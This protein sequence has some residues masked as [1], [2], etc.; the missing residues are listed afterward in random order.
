MTS[1]ILNNEEI[2]A[3]TNNNIV[4]GALKSYDFSSQE[5][6]TRG[7]YPTLDI[8]Y[9]RFIRTFKIAL[10]NFLHT[11]MVVEIENIHACK[12]NEYQQTLSNPIALNFLNIQPLKGVGLITVEFE[13]LY[14][15][16][17]TYFGGALSQNKNTLR[18][19]T[20]FENRMNTLLLNKFIEHLTQAWSPV[21]ALDFKI[22]NFETNP[23]LTTQYSPNE[24]MLLTCF[25]L[26]WAA[27]EGKVH[28]VLPYNIFEPIKS[29]IGTGFK[30]DRED[31]N[32]NWQKSITKELL[33]V[34]VDIGVIPATAS[35]NVKK[36]S[37]IKVGDIIPIS[38][39]ENCIVTLNDIPV[40][41]A[42]FGEF[43]GKYGIKIK[44]M[45]SNQG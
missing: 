11:D 4:E 3:F 34:A 16:V 20:P 41:T 1:D 12:F 33:T 32:N 23:M 22:K 35:I 39:S 13:L 28:F 36:L 26:K 44:D 42:K 24:M 10:V 9:E 29:V 25:K 7:R 18:E 31:L 27:G 8:I 40:Y 43:N 38:M 21:V 15:L 30:S 2:D 5:K 19:F 17:E 45:V 6:I 14:N 37:M